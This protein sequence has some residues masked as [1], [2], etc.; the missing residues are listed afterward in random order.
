MKKC[1][2]FHVGYPKC[3]STYLQEVIFPKLKTWN[4][5]RDQGEG[6]AFLRNPYYKLPNKMSYLK[7]ERSVISHE[8]ITE[9][10]YPCFISDSHYMEREYG[11]S[12]T[13]RVIKDFGYILVVIRRQD[14]WLES[15]LK[16]S[17]VFSGE[18][19]NVF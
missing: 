5:L 9:S 12:N 8:E 16:A 10:I 17:P 19:K 18:P 14:D 11:L 13:L 4:Y 3:A 6:M 7:N 2:I 1:S 15:I